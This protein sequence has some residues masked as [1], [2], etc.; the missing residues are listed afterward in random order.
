[1]IASATVKAIEDACGKEG[2]LVVEE[3]NTSVT[4]AGRPV[5]LV[6]IDMVTDRGEDFL[7]GSSVVKQDIWKAVVNATL[8]A[9]NRRL[10]TA[11]DD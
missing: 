3:V 7:I 4:M 2:Q 9:L 11:L 1:L 10:S 8:D 6:L 5:A